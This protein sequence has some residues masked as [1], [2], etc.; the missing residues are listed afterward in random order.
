MEVTFPS[1]RGPRLA[2]AG[3]VT[4]LL[5]AVLWVGTDQQ[6]NRI[7]FFNYWFGG[8]AA[9]HH[10]SPY[11]A[12]DAAAAIGHP[13]YSYHY[14]G[15]AALWLAPFGLLSQRLA[16]V[17]WTA[18]G[19]GFLVYGITQAGW[20]R[21]G[22]LA[23]APLWVS[24]LM[25]QTGPWT[26]AAAVLPWFGWVYAAKPSIGLALW[27]AWPRRSSV[28]AG[29]G[30]VLL[31]LLWLPGWPQA[32]WANVADAPFYLAP[33]RRPFGWLLLLG[34]LRW[35]EPGGRLIGA[36]ALIPHTTSLYEMMPLLLLAKRPRHLLVLLA[37]GWTAYYG[38]YT[39][40]SRTPADVVQLLAAQWP[41]ILT[42]CYLPALGLVLLAK[43]KNLSPIAE[44][45][46]ATR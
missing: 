46:E 5:A 8:L 37:L 45:S 21:L 30:L 2:I 34:W 40:T 27:L 32:W 29:A 43:S 17:L 3:A 7:D 31:S 36:L 9:L 25:G 4:I 16:Y 13:G 33:I 24:V 10:R 19:V 38:I 11:L 41:Y 23:S 39:Y 1:T 28:V 12:V 20:W 15:P 44:E 35:R 6:L 14:P 26:T 42:L 22:I 18:F